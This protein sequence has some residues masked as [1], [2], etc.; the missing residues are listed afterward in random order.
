V[1][2]TTHVLGFVNHLFFK[3]TQ[4]ERRFSETGDGE[5]LTDLG[6]LNSSVLNLWYQSD[7]CVM[8]QVFSHCLL[9][10]EKTEFTSREVHIG[11]VVDKVISR[12]VFLS[13]S[14]TLWQILFHQC[15]IMLTCHPDD[16]RLF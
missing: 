2:R 11:F 3:N 1:F 14:V 4:T 15:S 9:T 12:Q 13:T 10:A 7:G 6:P 8:T 16:R 5:A